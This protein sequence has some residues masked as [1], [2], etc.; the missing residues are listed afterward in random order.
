[1]IR[2]IFCVSVALLAA[3]GLAGEWEDRRGRAMRL[4]NLG[5]VYSALGQLP[6]ALECYQEALVLQ[7]ALGNRAGEAVH[8]TNLANAC[9]AGILR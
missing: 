2:L 3:Q 5:N 4:N 9:I 1:M 8:L 6:R 7:R